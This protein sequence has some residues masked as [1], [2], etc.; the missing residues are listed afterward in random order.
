[1]IKHILLLMVLFMA[2]LVNAQTPYTASGSKARD[3]GTMLGAVSGAKAQAE[4]CFSTGAIGL[5]KSIEAVSDRLRSYEQI[6]IEMH[7]HLVREI[8]KNYKK[9]SVEAAN[10]VQEIL[11]KGRIESSGNLD[12]KTLLIACNNFEKNITTRA[13]DLNYVYSALLRAIRAD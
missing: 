12:P 1:M 2:G 11:Y 4:R 13:G 6:E 7:Y 10:E 5:K 9:S 3:I 8:I